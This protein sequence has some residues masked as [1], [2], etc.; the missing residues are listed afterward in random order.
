MRARRVSLGPSLYLLTEA[1]K[2]DRQRNDQCESTRIYDVSTVDERT[3][4]CIQVFRPF[5]VIAIDTEEVLFDMLRTAKLSD[6]R[7]A[8][9]D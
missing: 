3:S 8:V 1:A 2:R 6:L 9:C 4:R 7:G 5:Q